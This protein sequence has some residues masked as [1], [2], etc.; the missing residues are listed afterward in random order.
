MEFVDMALLDEALDASG[1]LERWSRLTRF[2]LHLSIE[3]DIFVRKGRP[4]GFKDLAAEGSIR[5]QS[6]QFITDVTG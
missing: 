5:S 2:T 1:G 6:V 4:E 3:G